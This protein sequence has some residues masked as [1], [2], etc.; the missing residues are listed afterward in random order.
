MEATVLRRTKRDQ[1]KD[2]MIHKKIFATHEVILWGTQNYYNR[3]AQTKGDL[4]REGFLVRCA[5]LEKVVAGYNCKDEVY[6]I[7]EAS[8][9]STPVRL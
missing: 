1:L 3:A 5:D 4:V 9:V 7:A 2:W 8:R 6:A